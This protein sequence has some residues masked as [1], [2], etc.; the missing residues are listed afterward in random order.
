MT[1]QPQY[2]VRK[3]PH[4]HNGF[5]DP[6]PDFD[7]TC[8]ICGAAGESHSRGQGRLDAQAHI[9]A[10]HADGST[11]FMRWLRQQV[12]QDKANADTTVD[13][14]DRR[15]ALA[16]VESFT[17]I[18]DLVERRTSAVVE[19]QG[20]ADDFFGRILMSL[21]MQELIKAVALAYQH[22]DGYAEA[23]AAAGEAQ[24]RMQLSEAALN[25]ELAARRE[26]K[27]EPE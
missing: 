3:Q 7:W 10:A 4:H 23:L 19:A 1:D 22:R 16:R 5:Y 9:D 13:P 15:E 27:Q 6:D 11:T 2:T 20:P 12:A 17:A 24:V 14:L 18:L 21:A 26:R 8:L 25:D